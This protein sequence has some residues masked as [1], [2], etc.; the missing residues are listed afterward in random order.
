MSERWPPGETRFLGLSPRRGWIAAFAIALAVGSVC[1]VLFRMFGMGWVA[2]IATAGITVGFL[3]LG[4]L[5]W[6]GTAWWL[7][8]RSAEEEER[9]RRRR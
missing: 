1:L 2:G 3:W 5:Q 4:E 7:A 8:G 9:G 6:L